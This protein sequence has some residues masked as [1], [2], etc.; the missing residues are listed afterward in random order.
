[1]AFVGTKCPKTGKKNDSKKTEDSTQ[2]RFTHILQHTPPQKK[3]KSQTHPHNILA[4]NQHNISQD[5][6][7]KTNNHLNSTTR[8]G[9][10]KGILCHCSTATLT[11]PNEYILMY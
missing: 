10:E 4:T 7:N 11:A 1:M 9:N 3:Q 8:L 5:I 2:I 6:L